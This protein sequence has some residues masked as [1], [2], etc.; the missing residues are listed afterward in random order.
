MSLF[1]NPNGPVIRDDYDVYDAERRIGRIMLHPR[2]PA[3][4]P[5]FWT[6]TARW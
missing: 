6:I 3:E 2:A 1:L 4:R 5:W